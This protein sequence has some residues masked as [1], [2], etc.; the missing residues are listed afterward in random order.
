MLTRPRLDHS[1]RR[2]RI[3][4]S[5]AAGCLGLSPYMSPADAW[6]RILE[7]EAYEDDGNPDNFERGHVLEPALLEWASNKLDQPYTKPGTIVV[8]DWAACSVDGVLADG[9]LLEAKTVSA[10]ASDGWGNDGTEDI[11]DFVK[12]QAYWHLYAYP[13]ART[14]WVPFVG[15]YGLELR[16]YQVARH[17]PTIGTLVS[18]L[19]KWHAAY[20][21]TKTRPP[22]AM[23]SKVRD[24]MAARSDT[25]KVMDEVPDE[26]A[27]LVA[28]Y[29]AAKEAEEA[30]HALKSEAREA[31]KD[32]MGKYK[33]AKTDA[34]GITYGTRKGSARTDWKAAALEL[35]ITE[36]MKKQHTSHG[37]ESRVLVIRAKG[38]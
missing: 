28:D 38:G 27:G 8:A 13:K 2:N 19:R 30:A 16:L 34:W 25:L 33:S 7:P 36:E 3:T 37:H 20:V 11:P 26:L 15:D 18:A 6:A 35:G 14:C 21:V 12:I 10:R 9:N 32:A 17:Q 31:I 4:S 22:G 29:L 23:D 24:R 1:L 5:V